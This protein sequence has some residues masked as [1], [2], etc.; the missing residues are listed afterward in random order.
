MYICPSHC[1]LVL[2]ELFSAVVHKVFHF[3]EHL[4][5]ICP[6]GNAIKINFSMPLF[7]TRSNVASRKCNVILYYGL[8]QVN[9]CIIQDCEKKVK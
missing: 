3:V 5:V 7:A 1:D 2:L 9:C 8:D 6:F 4:D